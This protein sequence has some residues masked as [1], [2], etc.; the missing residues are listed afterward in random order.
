MIKE[1]CNLKL[2]NRYYWFIFITAV[3]LVDSFAGNMY[4][5]LNGQAKT[6]DEWVEFV[7]FYT[8]SKGVIT[9]FFYLLFVFIPLRKIPIQ[10]VDIQLATLCF[11]VSIFSSLKV[12]YSIEWNQLYFWIVFIF[13]YLILLFVKLGRNGKRS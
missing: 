11:L 4:L 3:F 10:P 8:A 7:K 12:A 1:L 13:F 6:L 5:I 2:L 9:A